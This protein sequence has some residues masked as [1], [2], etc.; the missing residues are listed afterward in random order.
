MMNTFHNFRYR[1]VFLVSSIVIFLDLTT[2]Y[3]AVYAT[4][5]IRW[6]PWSVLFNFGIS[7]GFEFSSI[8][9]SEWATAVVICATAV[10]VSYM[11]VRLA[12]S[13]QTPDSQVP[14]L[15]TGLLVGGIWANL[16]DRIFVGAVRDWLPVPGVYQLTGIAL[17]NNLADWAL[18]LGCILWI[19][20]L[21]LKT[22]T[23]S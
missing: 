20:Q 10:A 21:F 2:K 4:E 19:Y 17:Y 7:F 16:L 8:G 14:G 18:A 1:I 12:D 6:W 23:S 11:L 5:S 3:L 9:L 15:A 13:H 22:K